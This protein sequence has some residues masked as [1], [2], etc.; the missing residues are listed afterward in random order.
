[1]HCNHQSAPERKEDRSN[2]Y[3]HSGSSSVCISIHP[4]HT[5]SESLSTPARTMSQPALHCLYWS[6]SPGRDG[7][8]DSVAAL[9]ALG[10]L[11]VCLVY[12]WAVT[13]NAR[14]WGRESTHGRRPY[15]SEAVE[16]AKAPRVTVSFFY[17]SDGSAG[18]NFSRET[19]WVARDRITP[20]QGR[21]CRPAT[22][23]SDRRRCLACSRGRASKVH[24]AEHS[25]MTHN[26]RRARLLARCGTGCEIESGENR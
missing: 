1:L 2:Q 25:N 3:E 12:G 11:R 16:S 17:D 20:A 21:G 22:T 15:T 6:W 19:S 26:R 24:R 14:T 9:L 13:S 4:H 18:S 10:R 7:S 23:G 5:R 8:S